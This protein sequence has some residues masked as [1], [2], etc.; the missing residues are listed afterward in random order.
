MRT[1]DCCCMTSF[2]TIIFLLTACNNYY[3][4]SIVELEAVHLIDGQRRRAAMEVMF[5]FI[6]Y[7][8]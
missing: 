2:L 5:R 3:Y 8:G 1:S 7:V 6:I 4:G